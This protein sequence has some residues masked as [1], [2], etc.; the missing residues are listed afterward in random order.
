[1]ESRVECSSPTN[2][3]IASKSE[4]TTRI[5]F[6]DVERNETKMNECHEDDVL[7]FRRMTSR[8]RDAF[9]LAKRTA[10]PRDVAVHTLVNARL[11]NVISIKRRRS[12]SNDNR[13]Y[14][15]VFET[16]GTGL[17]TRR[18]RGTG[19]TDGRRVWTVGEKFAEQSCTY[20]PTHT[21][22]FGCTPCPE[23]KK[24]CTRVISF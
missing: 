10:S 15:V 17:F 14:R 13:R 6:F 5:G 23:Q 3:Y 16:D 12:Y 21:P 19:T 22:N 11:A 24:R 20:E 2:V 7:P 18:G 9:G 8:V 1:M 4:R